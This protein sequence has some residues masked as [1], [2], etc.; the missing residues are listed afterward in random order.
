MAR[1]FF[2]FGILAVLV[3]SEVHGDAR[4]ARIIGGNPTGT[5]EYPWM[6]YLK[7]ARGPGDIVLWCG[8]ALI[9][10]KYALTAAHCVTDKENNNIPYQPSSIQVVIGDHNRN[11]PDRFER[12]MN[13]KKIIVHDR[14]YLRD[15]EGDT[16]ND[17]ALL[18]LAEDVD[19]SDS[20]YTPVCLPTPRES[21]V[22]KTATAT[23]WGN[24]EEGRLS[25][26]LRSVD[27]VVSDVQQAGFLLAKG[28]VE[29]KG[30]CAGDSG[31]PLTYRGDHGPTLIGISSGATRKEGTLAMCTGEISRFASVSDYVDWIERNMNGQKHC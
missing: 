26:V 4:L 28:G 9:S 16:G 15:D 20:H 7:W 14:Y 18:E 23:G 25:D 31:G 24:T 30:T 27:L 2:L 19:I 29:R 17:I 8:G 3:L 12:A 11:L 1:F 6:V 22:G 13:V 5:N 21:F 10:S